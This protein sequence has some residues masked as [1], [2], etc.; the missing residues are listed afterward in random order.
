MPSIMLTKGT[1]M[2]NMAE[3]NV[4]SEGELLEVLASAESGLAVYN[5]LSSMQDLSD[6][7]EGVIAG[8]SVASAVYDLFGFGAGSVYNDI[9]VFVTYTGDGK[10]FNECPEY[11][12]TS[13]YLICRVERDRL[14]N[15]I[16]VLTL[17]DKFF[18]KFDFNCVQ[19]ALDIETK[20][21]QWSPEYSEF[22]KTKEIY[23]TNLGTPLQSMIRY[24]LKRAA[25]KESVDNESRIFGLFFTTIKLW[26]S[27]TAIED[28]CVEDRLP[29]FSADFLEKV[30]K[31]KQVTPKINEFI[32]DTYQ[33]AAKPTLFGFHLADM[34]DGHL[35][36]EYFNC[37]SLA[38]L[39]RRSKIVNDRGAG[40]NQYAF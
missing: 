4:I 3:I 24:A 7:T 5:L 32:A 23:V 37:S 22:C 38:S 6:I 26:N 27:P 13:S 33:D 2:S 16:E 20:T 9:D 10:D 34:K 8:Q 19:I 36:L 18:Y 25:L 35:D 12:P 1:N 30:E 29:L 31:A 40:D 39:L 28:M 17:K 15:K 11:K 14:V 21:L